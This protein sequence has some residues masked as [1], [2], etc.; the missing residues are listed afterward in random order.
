MEPPSFHGV[1]VVSRR[2]R[3]LFR[4]PPADSIS[5]LSRRRETG[6]PEISSRSAEDLSPFRN[7]D[8]RS[9]GRRGSPVVAGPSSIL[10]SVPRRVLP[11]LV[12]GWVIVDGL[13]MYHRSFPG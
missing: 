3:P 2:V 13:P 5:I 7:V 9:G 1:S 10:C 4:S 6:H 12:P 8:T 11:P